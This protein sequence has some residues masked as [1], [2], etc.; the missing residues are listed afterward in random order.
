MQRQ[1]SSQRP[2]SHPPLHVQKLPEPAEDVIDSCRPGGQP[3]GEVHSG[4]L[5]WP[6]V[7]MGVEVLKGKWEVGLLS[8]V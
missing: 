5:S 8:S 2:P 6:A 1:C 3:A 4:N 7:A